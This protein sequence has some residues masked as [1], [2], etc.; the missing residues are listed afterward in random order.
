MRPRLGDERAHTSTPHDE[1]R[2]GK[3]R[4]RLVHRHASAAVLLHQLVLERDAMTRPPRALEDALLNI[5]TDALMQRRTIGGSHAASSLCSVA[6]KRAAMG[7]RLACT[8][9]DTTLRPARQTPSITPR[10]LAKMKLSRIA[11]PERAAR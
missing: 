9:P 4:E 7:A 6:R 5:R 2:S 8:P 1:P 10:G 3:A 11:S